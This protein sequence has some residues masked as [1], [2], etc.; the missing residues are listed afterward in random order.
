VFSPIV[1][2][3][4]MIRYAYLLIIPELAK[5]TRSTVVAISAL[6]LRSTVVFFRSK[7]ALLAT[8]GGSQGWCWVVLIVSVLGADYVIVLAIVAVVAEGEAVL[9]QQC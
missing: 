3:I 8:Q 9:D 5:N 6:R 7:L 1:F 4:V 2:G